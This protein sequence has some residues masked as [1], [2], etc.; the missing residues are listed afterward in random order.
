M[1]MPQTPE[2][3]AQLIAKRDSISYVEALTAVRD[4]MAAM[5][6]AFMHGSITEVEDIL[7]EDLGLEPDYMDCFIM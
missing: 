2:E 6:L 3:V 4:A 1:K 5:E 7:R